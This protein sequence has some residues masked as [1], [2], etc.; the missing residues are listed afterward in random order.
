MCKYCENICIHCFSPIKMV[1]ILC[2]GNSSNSSLSAMRTTLHYKLFAAFLV[3]ILI[4]VLYMTLVFQWSFD[5]GFLDYVNTVENEQLQKIANNLETLFKEKK[6]WKWVVTNPQEL[7][8]VIISSYPEGELKQ[9][10]IKRLKEKQNST[11]IFTQGPFPAKAPV[12]FVRRVYLLDE[13]KQT[14][15]GYDHADTNQNVIKIYHQNQVVGYL[16]AHP[17]RHLS[18]SHQLVFAK[19]QK[20]A[21]LLVAIAG[22]LI[23]A[24]LAFPLAYRLTKPIRK[25]AQ[26]TR[27]LASGKYDTRITTKSSDE[28]SRLAEDLNDL[29]AILEKNRIARSQWIADISHELRTPLSILRGKI[30]GLQDG[31]YPA[32][33]ENLSDL[34]NEVVHLGLIVDD[35]YELSLS[36]IGAV[37]YNKVAIQPCWALEQAIQLFEAEILEK[38]IRLETKV[39]VED[40]IVLYGDNERLKQLFTNLLA[41]SIR[42]TDSSGSIHVTVEN[43]EKN[44]LYRIEDSAPGVADEHLGKLFERLYRVD[45]SRSRTSGGAG[46]G[47]SIC[48]NIVH[49]HN[50]TITAQHSELGGLCIDVQLPL[51]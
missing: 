37:T 12:H 23:A 3:A 40:D 36:D 43:S 32:T 7:A 30:E 10:F 27:S 50:G 5:R 14:I 20:L 33:A 41:N 13:N 28:F 46:L 4:V 19:Q 6:N 25:M 8:V 49:G 2:R 1:Y 16:G 26:A 47:L 35:L 15:I 31:V 22:V 11:D 42:Y 51:F 48:A 45:A 34:H 9:K 18:D 17:A 29:A 39:S 24:A 21:L 38:N 44:I